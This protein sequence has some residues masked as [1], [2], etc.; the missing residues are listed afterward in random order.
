MSITY[1]LVS[2]DA[3]DDAF[4]RYQFGMSS[5]G[6]YVLSLSAGTLALFDQQTGTT[7]TITSHFSATS[8]TASDFL[9]R[10]GRFVT[11]IDNEGTNS[12]IHLWDRDS[13]TTRTVY[14][15]SRLI[16]EAN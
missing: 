1:T 13:G 12:I 6:R 10:D 7:Q 14:T 5:D 9:S 2:P 16:F 4:A 11:Y 8:D 15:S 3:T